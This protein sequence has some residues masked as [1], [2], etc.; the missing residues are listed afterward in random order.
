MV[1]VLMADQ[2][3]SELRWGREEVA[4][5]G[6][7]DGEEEVVERRSLKLRVR[8]DRARLERALEQAKVRSVAV[9]T[10]VKLKS[11]SVSEVTGRMPNGSSSMAVVRESSCLCV[12]VGVGEG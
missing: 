9:E 3:G 5:E 10:E 1:A 6:L 2:L 8:E 4:E 12:T 7:E 11:S